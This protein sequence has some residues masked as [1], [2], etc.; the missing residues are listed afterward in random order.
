MFS[1]TNLLIALLSPAAIILALGVCDKFLGTPMTGIL[2]LLILVEHKLI[3]DLLGVE[4]AQPEPGLLDLISF[5]L[6]ET[7]LSATII[8]DYLLIALAVYVSLTLLTK[9]VSRTKPSETTNHFNQ[10]KNL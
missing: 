2:F 5:P 10:S 6:N 3:A 7:I 4:I 9:G 8:L 1:L